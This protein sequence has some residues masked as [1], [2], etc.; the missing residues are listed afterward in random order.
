MKSSFHF[1]NKCIQNILI[2]II[3]QIEI[4]SIRL[5]K[6][7]VYFYLEWKNFKTIGKYDY[8]VVLNGD[9][10]LKDLNNY[11]KLTKTNKVCNI[12]KIESVNSK[13]IIMTN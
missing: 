3:S 13:H 5:T 6:M 7:H 2:K 1:E 12:F 4:V 9:P 10:K 11:L 8:Y